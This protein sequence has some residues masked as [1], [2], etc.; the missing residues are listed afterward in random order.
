MEYGAALARYKKWGKGF[1][2][3]NLT[4][5]GIINLIACFMTSRVGIFKKTVLGIKF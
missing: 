3:L 5:S 1:F 2:A 4:R